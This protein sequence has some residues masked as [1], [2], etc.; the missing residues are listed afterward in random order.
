MLT[1]NKSRA[2]KRIDDFLGTVPRNAVS[3]ETFESRYE[4]E[5]QS[6]V[7]KGQSI[8]NYSP[9]V[10]IPPS[11]AVLVDGVHVYVE[12]LDYH[13]VL[14]DTQPERESRYM[15]ALQFLHIPTTQF[16]I[17]SWRTTSHSVS[18][19]MVHASMWLSP[20]RQA[21]PMSWAELSER[22]TLLWP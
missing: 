16:P 6:R 1:W 8:G 4:R 17:R 14:T 12:L 20:H 10:R 19:I 2:A 9:I 21:R 18:T 11:Q 3:V 15:R 13:S 7:T 5:L 22:W